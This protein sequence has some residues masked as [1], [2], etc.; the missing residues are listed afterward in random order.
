MWVAGGLVDACAVSLR[1][2]GNDLDPDELTQALG[3]E[4]TKSYRKG[5]IFRGKKYDYVRKTGSWL[6]S[7]D[8]CADVHLEAQI[9]ALLDKLPSDLEIWHS[10]TSKFEAD[11]FCGLWLEQWNRCLDFSPKTLQR[12]GERGLMLQFDIYA[13]CADIEEMPT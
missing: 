1:F 9:N 5:D 13:N 4:P 11:L 10:L 8:Q 12:M 2:F 7:I 3:I 6:F